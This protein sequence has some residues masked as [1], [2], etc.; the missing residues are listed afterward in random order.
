MGWRVGQVK[1]WG[2]WWKKR[3]ESCLE[4]I[5]ERL[6]CADIASDER[7]QVEMLRDIEINSQRLFP[8]E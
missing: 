8:F 7:R 1:A 3:I 5:M 4:D 6:R 2:R